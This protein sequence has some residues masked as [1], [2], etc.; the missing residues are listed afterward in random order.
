M[1]LVKLASVTATNRTLVQLDRKEVLVKVDW[2][3]S[4]AKLE[5]LVDQDY[6]EI[7]HQFQWIQKENVFHAHM[8]QQVQ[9]DQLEH[10]DLQDQKDHVARMAATALTAKM[11][12]QVMLATQD[13]RVKMEDLVLRVKRVPMAAKANQ[14]EW[15]QKDHQAHQVQLETQDQ[16]E[17]MVNQVVQAVQVIKVPVEK[18]AN[19]VQKALPVHQANRAAQAKMPNIVLAH[20]GTK[21]L[22]NRN[23]LKFFNLQQKINLSNVYIFLSLAKCNLL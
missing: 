5:Q 1:P 4:L 18:M 20:E 2:T 10:Q 22:R 11:V 12:H 21:R 9:K 8:V 15:V 16:Q 7:I 23:W 6:Q 13:Q 17:A 19:Q 3:D 14:A